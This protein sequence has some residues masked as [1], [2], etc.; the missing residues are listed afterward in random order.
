MEQDASNE[1][2]P[3]VKQTKPHQHS[4]GSSTKFAFKQGHRRTTS[5]Q[6]LSPDLNSKRV[7]GQIPFLRLHFGVC[8]IKGMRKTQEDAH[9]LVADLEHLGSGSDSETLGSTPQAQLPFAFFGI[10]DGHGGD[11][12]SEF[13]C[14]N[15]H[16]AFNSHPNLDTRSEPDWP[17]QYETAL[18]EAFCTVERQYLEKVSITKDCSGTTAAVA[19]VKENQL[20]VGNVGDSEIVLC[21]EGNKAL[22]LTEVHNPKRNE[23]EAERVENMGGVLYQGRVAHPV[24]SPELISIAVSRAIGDYGF[25]KGEFTNDKESGLIAEPYVMHLTLLPN[26]HNFL[27]IACDC[28]WDVMDPQAAVDFVAPKLLKE[29]ITPQEAA[30]LLVHEAYERGST[31]NITASII[32]FEWNEATSS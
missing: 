32:S 25:K 9:K 22:T 26:K 15:L 19:V 31:D 1:S 2:S 3:E 13:V 21:I 20:F 23:K 24:Y 10:Y 30:K 18:R 17:D 8:S 4:G 7:D 29:K 12:A 14:A 27:I 6:H 5:F 11:I 16:L 28:V